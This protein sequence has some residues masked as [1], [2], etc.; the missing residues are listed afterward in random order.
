MLEKYGKTLL[1]CDLLKLGH[2]GSSS[3]SSMEFLRAVS[4]DIAVISCAKDNPYGYP[5]RETTANLGKLGVEV[6]R[7]DLS[8]SLVFMTDGKTITTPQK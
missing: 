7:T 8:G 1:D 2:H 3:S 5:H 6:Y 4:S